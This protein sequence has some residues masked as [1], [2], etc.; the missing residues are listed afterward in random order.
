MPNHLTSLGVMALAVSAVS[1]CTAIAADG[2]GY[3]PVGLLFGVICV[4]MGLRQR[5]PPQDSAP[6]VPSVGLMA[7][8]ISCIA[9]VPIILYLIFGYAPQEATMGLA[10]KIFYFHVPA[11]YGMYVG[12]AVALVG[13]IGYLWKGTVKKTVQVRLFWV[14]PLGKVRIHLT[15]AGFDALGVAGAEVG[16]MF[17]LAVLITGP[18]WA[19]EAWGVYW[20]WDSRLTTTLLAGLIFTGAVVLR[21]FGSGDAEK[22]FASGLAIVGTFLVPII[23]R[24]VQ[25]WR[26]QHPTVLTARGGGLDHDMYP[27][28]FGSLFFFTLLVSYLI[29]ARYRLER[30]RSALLALE[31][32]A[33]ELGLLEDA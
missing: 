27:A 21:S 4:V 22:R 9:L 26:G 28:F 25:L 19:R 16:L 7:L 17:C 23:N 31:S 18:L 2:A 15:P 20:T 29:W 33:A 13:A 11:A 24:S 8:G 32:D 30:D 6:G 14:I 3:Y 12:F 1:I 10:Q 5:R